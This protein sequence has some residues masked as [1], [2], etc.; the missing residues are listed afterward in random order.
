MDKKNDSFSTVDFLV[1]GMRLELT[2]TNVRYPL[3]VVRLPI[4]PSSHLLSCF[5]PLQ[6]AHI[7]YHKKSDLSIGYFVKF[8][9]IEKHRNLTKHILSQVT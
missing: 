3:K 9:R 4:P 2:R 1:R 8:S 6:N 7:L 5:A